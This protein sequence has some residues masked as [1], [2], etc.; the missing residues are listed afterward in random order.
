[1]Y[2]LGFAHKHTS[3]TSDG[4]LLLQPATEPTTSKPAT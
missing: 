2:S 4:E 1:M 3:C